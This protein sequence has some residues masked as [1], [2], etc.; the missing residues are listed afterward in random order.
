M[1]EIVDGGLVR[2]RCHTGH[3]FTL[4]TL[5]AAQAEAWERALYKAYRAQH[6]RSM[7]LRRWRSRRDAKAHR[8]KAAGAARRELRG[9]RAELIRRLIAHGSA[10]ASAQRGDT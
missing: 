6:E 1:Q 4:E 3:A 2:Y 8:G 7:V 5:G 10:G 9:G